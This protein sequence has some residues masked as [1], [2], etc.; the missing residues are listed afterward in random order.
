MAWPTN[1]PNSDKFSSDGDSIKDSRPELKKMSDAVNDIVDFVDTTGIQNGD[2]LVYD[3]TSGTIKPGAGGG[4]G[5]ISGNTLTADLE[6]NG[7]IIGHLAP[8]SALASHPTGIQFTD[9]NFINLISTHRYYP[10]SAG[11]PNY[12]G[13]GSVFIRNYIPNRI[14]DTNGQVL[15]QLDYSRLAF[16]SQGNYDSAEADE[17]SAFVLTESGKGFLLYHASQTPGGAGTQGG[18][19]Q[20]KLDDTDGILIENSVG[21]DSA[22]L[23]TDLIR[24]KSKGEIELDSLTGVKIK[25]GSGSASVS[26]TLD[27]TSTTNW[28]IQFPD[29][30][31]FGY[32]KMYQVSSGVQ[33]LLSTT[34]PNT[35]YDWQGISGTGTLTSGKTYYAYGGGTMTLSLPSG[36]SV[37]N[38]DTI[39]IVKDPSTT[40]DINPNT[41]NLDGSSANYTMNSGW[42]GT[43]QSGSGW[44]TISV[45]K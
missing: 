35:D 20:I 14:S 6:T 9:N 42:K 16:I 17:Y 23:Y 32:L 33:G 45:G 15:N 43:Y 12:L 38:G 44:M 22:G 41:N 34:D 28:G 1:K 31:L 37:T 19:H 5:G 7:F 8:D 10:D 39:Q 40:V 36:G 27:P 30:P 26:F 4:G 13:A 3:S 29:Q 21:Q 2:V 11:D 18:L 25:Q 24:V